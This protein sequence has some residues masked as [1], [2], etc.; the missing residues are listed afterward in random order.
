MKYL[1]KEVV[2]A[3]H[4]EHVSLA[5]QITQ[6]P[7]KCNGCHS[8][9]LREDIGEE[10]NTTKFN[11]ILDKYD[12]LIDNV[13]FFGGDHLVDEM[14]ELLVCAHMRGLKTT[15]WSGK[16]HIED[17]LIGYLDYLKLGGFD[18]RVGGLESENTNQKYFEVKTGRKI[19]IRKQHETN[20]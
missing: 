12:G 2:F 7:N 15:L 8:P 4:P 11:Y 18:E 17:S 16:D 13:I 1:K 14:K 20:F 19:S 9:E 5:F 10:I 3:E 6:C